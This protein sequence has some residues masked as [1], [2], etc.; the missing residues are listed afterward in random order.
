MIP[1]CE[2]IKNKAVERGKLPQTKKEI[3]NTQ[4]VRTVMARL[5][6]AGFAAVVMLIASPFNSKANDTK[7]KVAT[8]SDKQVS[9]KYTGTNDNS[10]V[11]RVQF[12][13]PTAQKFSFIIKNQAGDVLFSGQYTDVNFAKTVHLLKEEEEMNPTFIIR[14]G[15]QVIENSFSINSNVNVEEETV[16]TKL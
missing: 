15:S 13:N 10:V 6:V 7:E 2:K 9:V 1:L 16:V 14:A 4:S 12:T 8:V 3:M 11:F 5:T